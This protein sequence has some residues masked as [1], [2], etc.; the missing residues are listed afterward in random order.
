MED[1]YRAVSFVDGETITLDKMNQMETNLQW[2]NDNTPRGRYYR[3]SGSP[4]DV[5]TIVVGG[6]ALVKKNIKSDSAKV[7]VRFGRAFSSSC[8]PNVT[9]GICSDFQTKIFC[10]VNGPKGKLFPDAT[11]FE[12]YVNIAADKAT[13]DRI[14]KD[15]WIHWHAFGYRDDDMNEF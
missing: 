14:R 7:S 4:L 6:K 11:G 9:V 15:F 1:P 3:A 2:I 12:I 10:V 8:T 5:R 13:E